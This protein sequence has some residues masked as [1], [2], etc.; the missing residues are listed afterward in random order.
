MNDAKSSFDHIEHIATILV[1]MHFG[2]VYSFATTLFYILRKALHKIKT[3][4]GVSDPV[5]GNKEQPLAGIGQG[6][7]LGPAL[8]CLISSIIVKMCRD[9]EHG[10]T[11]TSSITKTETPLIGFA[12]VDDVDLISGADHISTIGNELI[13][14]FQ[15][16][17]L[18]WNDGIHTS[19]GLIVPQK[20]YWFLIDF[21]CNELDWEISYKI[22]NA[23]RHHPSRKRW[24]PIYSYS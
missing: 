8:W 11:I 22:I 13:P 6:N 21:I 15:S 2:I 1:L 12:F 24:R 3:R 23:W 18:Q 7:G 5:Y 4:Y 20:T 14:K 9:K 10:I 16:L 17:L 19:R